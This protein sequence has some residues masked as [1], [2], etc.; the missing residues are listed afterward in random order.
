[1]PDKPDQQTSFRPSFDPSIQTDDIAFRTEDMIACTCGRNSPPNRLKCLYCGR[2]LDIDISKGG[3]V[4]AT[5]RPLELWERGFNVVFTQPVNGVSLDVTTVASYLSIGQDEVKALLAHGLPLPLARVESEKEAMIVQHGLRELGLMTTIVSDVD[6]AA[7]KMPVRLSGIVF[8]T[9]MVRF[10]AFNTG[11][12]TDV[13][14]EKLAL[15]VTGIIATGRVEAIEKRLRGGN[16][17]VLDEAETMSDEAVL[18]IYPISDPMGFRVNLTGFDFGCLGSD[19]GLLAAENI[20]KLIA[21]LQAHA[22]G[23]KLVD[24]YQKLRHDIGCVWEIDTRRSPTGLQRSGFA[25]RQFG[26]V[27]STS[28][29]DQF[30]KYSR[31]QQHLY[32]TKG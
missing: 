18:D 32:E 25:R 10:K 29:L 30:T 5:L 12:I 9:G 7:D 17:E 16:K 14:A 3:A 27:T 23:A 15:F 8:D 21:K 6:L 2:E 26:S 19:K 31:L 4:K 22:P 1:M 24:D 20:V 28:N 13:P 11:E